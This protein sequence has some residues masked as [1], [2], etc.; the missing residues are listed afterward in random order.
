MEGK[1][2]LNAVYKASRHYNAKLYYVL[3]LGGSAKG[4]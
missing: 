1:K 3:L 2:D 4:T